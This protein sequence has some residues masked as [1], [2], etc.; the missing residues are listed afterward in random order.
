MRK[1]FKFGAIIIS[2]IYKALWGIKVF[3]KTEK[4]NFKI[5]TFTGTSETVINIQIWTA[6][7]Y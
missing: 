3:F 7:R 2:E 4:Q 6:H 5:K 1:N